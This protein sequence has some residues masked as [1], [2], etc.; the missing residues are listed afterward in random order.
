MKKC[1]TLIAASLVFAFTG[2]V[3]AESH[4]AEAFTVERPQLSGHL[5][6]GAGDEVGNLNPYGL[7]IGARG[8]YTLDKNIYLGGVLDFF[9]GDSDS[10]GVGGLATAE[11]SASTWLL[12][13]EGGYDFGVTSSIVIRPKLGLGLTSAHA[14]ICGRAILVGSNCGSDTNTDF[15][16]SLGV[17]ALFDVGPVY[18]DP[19]LRYNIVF[20]NDPDW[21]AFIMGVGVGTTF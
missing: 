7:G 1:S 3:A 8:G 16:M 21:N 17:E 14:K 4:A 10:V 9:F 18:I 2:L 6:F 13:A 20:D 11:S 19:E 15:S 12:Q 5:L